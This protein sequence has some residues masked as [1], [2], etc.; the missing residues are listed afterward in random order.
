MVSPRY[1]LQIKTPLGVGAIQAS[2]VNLPDTL[3]QE[4]VIELVQ[5]FFDKRLITDRATVDLLASTPVDDGE[6][7]IDYDVEIIKTFN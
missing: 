4:D 1:S 2:L 6:G 5:N 7:C 3:N